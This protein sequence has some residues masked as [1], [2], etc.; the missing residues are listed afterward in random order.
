MN[1]GYD[2]EDIVDAHL[3]S[4]FVSTG[5]LASAEEQWNIWILH[6]FVRATRSTVS[7]FTQEKIPALQETQKIVG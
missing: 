4:L 5:N 1:E 7:V 6:L 3:Q 2:M